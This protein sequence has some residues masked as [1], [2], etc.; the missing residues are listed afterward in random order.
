MGNM[1]IKTLLYKVKNNIK[2][3]ENNKYDN[4][5]LNEIT[6]DF[7]EMLE[8]CKLFLISNRDSYYGYFVMNM[9]FEMDYKNDS[10]AGIKLNTYPPVFVTNPLLLGKL[11]LNQILYVICHEIDHIVLNHPAEMIKVNPTKSNKVFLEFNYAADASVN[12]RIN[13]EI[14]KEN[15]KF[16]ESPEGIITSKTIGE[17]CNIDKIKECESYLYYFNLLH[18]NDVIDEEDEFTFSNIFQEQN[19]GYSSESDSSEGS[20]NSSTSDENNEETESNKQEGNDASDSS[21]IIDSN[22]F[23]N[24][25]DHSWDAGD[26]VEEALANIKELMNNAYNMMDKEVRGLM[27]GNFIEAIKKINQPPQISWKSLFKKYIGTISSEKKST[28]TRL[29]RR[30]PERFDLS[31]KIS[32][33]TLKIAIAIDTSGSLNSRMLEIIFVEIFEIISNRKFELTVIECDTNIRKV[34]RVNKKSDLDMN[35]IGRGGT[36]FQPVIDYVNDN[37]YFRDSLLI[38]FTDGFGESKITKPKTYRNLWVILGSKNNLSLTEP[39]GNVVE[40]ELEYE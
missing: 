11:N 38:Y 20:N 9:N 23:G 10:L 15:K 30:Q 26:D 27:P 22:N 36:A 25:A 12:D 13:R 24:S 40:L 14:S 2:L 37:K 3:V 8:L 7:T 29:N 21:D 35:I 28:R 1:N 6:Y 16:L 18:E 32:D 33:K 4:E 19:E 17:I 34:Y 39:Y 5:V 31:G